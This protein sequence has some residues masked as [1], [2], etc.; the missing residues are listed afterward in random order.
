MQAKLVYQGH[1]YGGVPV[2]SDLPY[3]TFDSVLTSLQRFVEVAGH[4]YSAPFWM[5]EF[6]TGSDN[7]NWRKILRFIG[8]HDLDW[9]VWCLDGYQ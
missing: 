8:E 2:L 9:G 1:I 7:E 3:D 4:E 6:G 5:G